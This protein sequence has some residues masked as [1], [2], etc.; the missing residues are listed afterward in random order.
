[1][2]VLSSVLSPPSKG[3]SVLEKFRNNQFKYFGAADVY[4]GFQ[5]EKT[6]RQLT[7]SMDRFGVK[8]DVDL[9]R[10]DPI[11]SSNGAIISRLHQLALFKNLR[12]PEKGILIVSS[13][14]HKE[15]LTKAEFE[16]KRVYERI[17]GAINH[18]VSEDL[19][20]TEEFLSGIPFRMDETTISSTPEENNL[21]EE[22]IPMDFNKYSSAKEIVDLVET[23]LFGGKKYKPAKDWSLADRIHV[24]FTKKDNENYNNLVKRYIFLH[25]PPGRNYEFYILIFFE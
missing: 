8:K 19:V 4:A 9:T 11:N 13:E 16:G 20:L 24:G 25:L 18:F 5:I 10:A 3:P 12:F 14:I 7:A 2:S 1:M 15:Q 23:G 6:I 21:V 17:S 22:V